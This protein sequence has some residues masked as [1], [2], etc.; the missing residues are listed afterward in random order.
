LV[1]LEAWHHSKP[2][3]AF[4]VPAINEIVESGIDGELVPPFDT[5]GLKRALRALLL[6]PDRLQSMGAAGKRKQR[7]MYGIATMVDGIAANQHYS[8][9]W[10]YG[11][12]DN[13][14]SG[15]FMLGDMFKGL[16][17]PDGSADGKFLPA[18]YRAVAD[19]FGIEGGLSSADKM[20][21][22]RAFTIASAGWSGSPVDVVTATVQR[23]GKSV[24]VQAVEVPASLAYD[25]VDDKGAPNELARG[26]VERVR[27]NLELQGLP[28]PADD[29]L[30]EQAK[31]LKVKCVG[32]NN[33]IFGKVPS[34][35]DIANKLAPAAIA[36][37]YM[38]AKVNRTKA[39]NGEKFGEALA[40]VTKCLDEVLTD[41]DESSFAPSTAV[42]D[43]LRGLA[44][45]IAAYFAA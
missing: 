40:Y 18:A 14:V 19:N 42:E 26:L 16:T 10:S 11:V 39:A 7:E 34:A 36:G 22:Q 3:V 28:V 35:T 21:F 23:K 9:R 24:K 44:E 29:V 45:R 13:E 20:A 31:A 1:V 15:V 8:M 12:G 33:P 25:L 4:D 2:V 38:Q 41:T 32:G 37:G 30:L 5:D 43:K 6:D 17:H 27:G